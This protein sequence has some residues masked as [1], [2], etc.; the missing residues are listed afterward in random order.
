MAS[1]LKVDQI[2]DRTNNNTAIEVDGSGRVSMP[3]IPYAT[4]GHTNN[5]AYVAKSVGDVVDFDR[6]LESNGSDYNTSTYKYTAPLDGLYSVSF[7]FLTQNDTDK[8]QIDVFKNT[9]RMFSPYTV[10]RTMQ[11]SVIIPASS[12]DELYLKFGNAF[13]FYEGSRPNAM[14]NYATYMFMG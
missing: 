8:Y 3:K 11:A 9:T 6:I 7:G 4:V 1:I 14:Y 2:N 10:Y 5:L 12:G 13:N